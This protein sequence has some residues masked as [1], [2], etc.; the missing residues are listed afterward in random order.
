VNSA[1]RTSRVVSHHPPS[2]QEHCATG[3]PVGCRDSPH[4]INMSIWKTSAIPSGSW[5]MA[6][7]GWAQCSTHGTPDA[8]LTH[9]GCSSAR[10]SRGLLRGQQCSSS[11]AGRAR[12]PQSCRPGAGTSAS[13]SRACKSRSRDSGSHTRRSSWPTSRPW[14]FDRNQST[15]SWR[16][17][18]S[19]TYRRKSSG[20]PSNGSTNGCAPV[21]G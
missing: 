14:P 20:R 13:I 1:R 8:R 17:M 6:T 18:C 15:A 12:T 4:R 5:R 11:D 16:S 9:D 7:I 21:V 2:D 10:S 3:S 19:C